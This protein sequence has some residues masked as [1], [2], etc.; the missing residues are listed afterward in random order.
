MKRLQRLVL[1]GLLCAGCSLEGPAWQALPEPI[2]APH[3]Q[4][5][6]LKGGV[7][8]LESLR[9]QV[10]V[11][12]FWATW[13]GPCRYTMPSLDLMQKRFAG[14]GVKV[15]MIN[16]GENKSKVK[17]YIKDRFQ[18]TILLDQQDRVAQQYGITAF[19]SLFIIDQEGMIRYAKR[20]YKGGLEK[21]LS[22]ILADLIAEKKGK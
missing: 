8:S 22:R 13:C 14:K 11:M 12:E 16:V 9:G 6:S 2:A 4:L 19:P 1:A 18:S 21:Q 17:A 5:Q 7:L 15:L 10:V 20:G 3:F